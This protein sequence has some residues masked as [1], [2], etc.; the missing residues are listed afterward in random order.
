MRSTIERELFFLEESERLLIGGAE[1]SEWSVFMSKSVYSAFTNGA[2]LPTIIT[3]AA[4]IEAY[5]RAGTRR[6]KGLS[7]HHLI[8]QYSNENGS[9]LIE[10][11][12]EFRKYRNKWVHCDGRDE[13]IVFEQ[14]DALFNELEEWAFKSITL[15]FEVL[16]SDPYV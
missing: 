12:H 1:I 2:D 6:A 7:L 4:C 11:L 8:S 16:Y 10:R 3:V 13:E 15:L 9:E 5:L 14:E